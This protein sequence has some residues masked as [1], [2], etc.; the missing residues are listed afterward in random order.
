MKDRS[1]FFGELQL[2]QWL[3]VGHRSLLETEQA[4]PRQAGP[5][6]CRWQ[7]AHSGV[8]DLLRFGR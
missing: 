2:N 8:T 5:W 6:L 3:G 4:I 1:L 7:W